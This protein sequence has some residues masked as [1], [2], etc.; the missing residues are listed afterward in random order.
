MELCKSY[1]MLAMVLPYIWKQ[2]F[3][4]VKNA[5]SSSE[6]L[7][8]AIWVKRNLVVV[9][10]PCQIWPCLASVMCQMHSIFKELPSYTIRRIGFRNVEVSDQYDV[11]I[12]S[13]LSSC[14]DSR[15]CPTRDIVDFRNSSEISTFPTSK[16][17]MNIG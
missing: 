9:I 7:A 16:K 13:S 2:D 15:V 8:G 6:I 12:E 14:R 10:G 17:D 1:E 5:A 11:M 4:K 3:I